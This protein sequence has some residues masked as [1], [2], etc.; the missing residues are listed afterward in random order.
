MWL[1]LALVGRLH[2]IPETLAT[3]REHLDSLSVSDRGPKITSEL[4][5]MT[6]KTFARPDLPADLRRDPEFVYANVHGGLAK[7]C[8]RQPWTKFAHRCLALGYKLRFLTPRAPRIAARQVGLWAI[9]SYFAIGRLL[10]DRLDS[11][12]GEDDS[13]ASREFALISYYLPPMWSGGAVVLGRILGGIDPS[14]YCLVSRFNHAGGNSADFIA[15][16][17]APYHH[18]PGAMFMPSS[19]NR[20]L[21]WIHAGVQIVVRSWKLARVLKKEGIDAV[22]VTTGDLVELPAAFVA[23]RLCGARYYVYLFDD[24]ISQ[25]WNLDRALEMATR[26]EGLLLHRA[27]GIIATNEFMAREIQA[28]YGLDAAIVRNPCAKE[29]RANPVKVSDKNNNAPVEIVFTGAVYHVNLGAI[30][31][32]I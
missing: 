22:V 9:K 10:I 2:H 17:P 27:S 24:F 13:S 5:R 16:L 21:D 28:R 12:S 32:L 11:R 20:I 18:V 29:N 14:K 3:H 31:L 4:K 7:Y 6:D 15:P 1:R 25:W 30:E 23:A 8:E 19:R 26:L